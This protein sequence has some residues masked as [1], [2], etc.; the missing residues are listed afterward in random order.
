MVHVSTEAGESQNDARIEDTSHSEQVPEL[1]VVQTRGPIPEAFDEHRGEVKQDN[2]DNQ[3][4][5]TASRAASL[6]SDGYEPPESLPA[7]SEPEYSPPFSPVAPEATESK[8][9]EPTTDS[10][11]KNP[12]A[13]ILNSQVPEKQ[14]EPETSQVT[15]I[16][17]VMLLSNMK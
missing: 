14:P 9:M 10:A 15:L 1:S 5:L 2:F 17:F 11:N 8:D 7:P 6:V 13:L 3:N 12:E 4:N 16:T